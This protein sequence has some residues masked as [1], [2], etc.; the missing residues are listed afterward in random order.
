MT[1]AEYNRILMNESACIQ[2]GALLS[3]VVGTLDQIYCDY[4][5]E[6]QDESFVPRKVAEALQPIKHIA[7][8]L[9]D[10]VAGCSYVDDAWD[11]ADKVLEKVINALTD[12]TDH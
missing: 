11:A 8:I 12:E 3:D 7:D 6:P 1:Y 2:I 4:N 10:K 5:S 9:S